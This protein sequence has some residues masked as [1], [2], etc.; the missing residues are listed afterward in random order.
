MARRLTPD[1]NGVLLVDDDVFLTRAWTRIL[2]LHGHRVFVTST[3]ADT[4]A[5]VAAWADHV[6][7]YV[8]LDLKLP[9][10]DGA[11]LLP[12]FAALEPKPL[13]AV[14]SA[15]LDYERSLALHGQCTLCVPK[16]PDMEGVIQLIEL[17]AK[18]R[19][20]HPGHGYALQLFARKHALDAREAAVVAHLMSGPNIGPDEALGCKLTT[21]H[22]LW[23]QVFEKTGYQSQLDVVRAVRRLAAD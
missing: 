18:S 14:V 21:V 16:P 3:V 1:G 15:H 13:V 20:G 12:L 11:E 23:D 19:R 17:L 9:D 2:E 6:C 7:G 22:A 8:L 10:G 5:H 4:E